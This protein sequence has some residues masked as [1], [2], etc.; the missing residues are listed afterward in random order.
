MNDIA[1]GYVKLVLQIGLYD[2]GYVDAYYGPENWKPKDISEN[3]KK[4]FPFA[5]LYKKA[6]DLISQLKKIDQSKLSSIEK[7][8]YKYLFD[9][10]LSVR[11]RIEILNGK[12]L[13]FD[14]ESKALYDAVSPVYDEKFFK[15]VI[16]QLD[17]ILP[18][19]GSISER[20]DKFRDAFVIPKEK[21]DTVFKAAIFECR[22]RT[23]EHISLPAN[24]NFTVEYVTGKS[25]GA[26]NWYKGNEF[27]LIQVNTELPIYI[28]R[29]IDLAC[30]EGYPGHH[31]YNALLEKHL[32]DD[33]GWVEFTVYPLFSPQSL[34]AEGSANYGI[35][36]AFPGDERTNFEKKVLFP[37]AGLDSSLAD[38]YYE[39]IKL[40]AKL[41]YAMNEAARNYLDGKFSRDA[42]IA[43][44]IKYALSNQDRAE[45]SL[46]FIEHYRSYVIN[47]NLGQDIVKNYIE[48]NGGTENDNDKRWELFRYLI[49]TPQTPSE[50][51]NSE[52]KNKK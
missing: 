8:R 46:R 44:L 30:H 21:I 17:R 28:D 34:I 22:K 16:D 33:K 14:E 18:G 36:V 10:I 50:L 27:S 31:V 3:E 5:A 24:E 47:Y 39:A 25:W 52:M 7:L 40:T 1:E 19:K 11:S 26:Y 38:K 48:R 42:A 20:Y 13:S 49:S 43:F 35:D 15:D 41:N 23:L 4:D 12:K 51:Q 9:Q 29:A 6:N 37:L 32:V 45:R 2:D